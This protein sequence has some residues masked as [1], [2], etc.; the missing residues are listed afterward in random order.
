[1]IHYCEHCNFKSNYKWAVRRHM[2]RIHEIGSDIQQNIYEASSNTQSQQ[3]WL[4]LDKTH[5]TQNE[6][7]NE[8]NEDY[9]KMV[10]IAKDGKHSVI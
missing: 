1:M 7:Y 4:G 5:Y 10:G 9:N 8:D 2:S 6:N 3:N